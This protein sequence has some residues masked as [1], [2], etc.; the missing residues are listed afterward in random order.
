MATNAARAQASVADETISVDDD[1]DDDDN[2]H[3]RIRLYPPWHKGPYAVFIREKE[4]RLMPL[5]FSSYVYNQYKS[6]QAVTSI[7]KQKKIKITLSELDDANALIKDPVFKNYRVYIR[8]DEVEISG[9]INNSEICDLDSLDD[10]VIHGAGLFTNPQQ[11]RVQIVEAY[12]F[13]STAADNKKSLSNVI[14]VTFVGRAL[15]SHVCIYGL[16][17][18]VRPWFQRAMFCDICQRFKH[19]SKYCSRNPKCAKCQGDHLTSACDDAN[20]DQSI[21]PYC[22][23][24]HDDGKHNCPHFRKV[25]RDYF[26][27]QQAALLRNNPQ[28]APSQSASSFPTLSPPQRAVAAAQQNRFDVLAVD[29]P[30]EPPAPAIH[31]VA[32]PKASFANPWA[33]QQPTK[34]KLPPHTRTVRSAVAPSTSKSN[35]QADTP[36][37]PATRRISSTPAAAPGL[38]NPIPQ[39]NSIA[40][41][42]IQICS[43]I[44]LADNW[45]MIVRTIAP[46]I[47]SLI[48][49]KMSQAATQH[50]VATVA[51]SAAQM[52]ASQC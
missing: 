4:T 45:M 34:R 24:T 36:A 51:H 30:V 37:Q 38:C 2:N 11:E 47:A 46:F 26:K 29:E 33:K 12:R 40:D 48:A 13:D 16:L 25:N 28:V 5:K 39:A 44:G 20:T 3:T 1:G 32:P 27:S 23:E 42:I 52:N 35:Q 7:P 15:P 10:L 43:A 22:N 19:T 6:A 49:D 18:K 41:V 50:P 21:C 17:L 31:N 9:V 8:S 14:K